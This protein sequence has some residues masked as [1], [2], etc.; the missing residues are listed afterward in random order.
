M[1]KVRGVIGMGLSEDFEAQEAG[2]QAL[3]FRAASGEFEARGLALDAAAMKTLGLVSESG[4]YTRLALLLSDQ[5]PSVVKLARFSDTEAE[6]V[7]DRRELTGSLFSQIE[8]LADYLGQIN[9]LG[10]DFDGMK[11]RDQRSYPEAALREALLN[12]ILHRDY[13]K[14]ADA[15]VGIYPDRVECIS[16]GG[17]FDGMTLED[18]LGGVPLCRN[19]GLARVL[20]QLRLIR[21]F[22]TGIRKIRLAYKDSL[23]KPTFAA[24]PNAF[25]VTLPN[26]NRQLEAAGSLFSP[27]ERVLALLSERKAVTRRDVET[28]LGISPASASRLLRG[29]E[30][31]DLIL[32]EANGPKTHF[33]RKEVSA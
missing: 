26:R 3:T 30:T 20:C 9:S 25:K 16:I 29:M 6:N 8:A 5:N 24:L 31:Q 28:L 12:A 2:E 19:P 1:R 21:A 4:R 32:R 33:I 10:S 14:R 7:A 15:L 18:A 22:G 13:S 23:M 27:E 11:R 17:L